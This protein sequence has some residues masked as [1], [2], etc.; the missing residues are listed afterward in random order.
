MTKIF[1][2][3]NQGTGDNEVVASPC[4][5]VMAKLSWLPKEVFATDGHDKQLSKWKQVT[6]TYSEVMSLK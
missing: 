5:Y 6:S 2:F 4:S 1:E 3:Q